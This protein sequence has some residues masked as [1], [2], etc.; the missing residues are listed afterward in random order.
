MQRCTT[1]LAVPAP[2]PLMHRHPRGRGH[3]WQGHSRQALKGHGEPVSHPCSQAQRHNNG[4]AQGP[5]QPAPP[6]S[7]AG[8]GARGHQ[9]AGTPEPRQGPPQEDT[10]SDSDVEV[11]SAAFADGTPAEPTSPA[12]SQQALCPAL[13]RGDC[14]GGGWCPKQHPWPAADNGALPVVGHAAAPA[15]LRYGVAQAWTQDETTHGSVNIQEDVE[16][17]ANTGQTEVALHTRDRHGGLAEGL[18]VIPTRMVLVLAADMVRVVLHTSWVRRAR[19]QWTIPV[20]SPP[21]A[22]Q[23]FPWAVLAIMWHLAAEGTQRDNTEDIAWALHTWPV[24]GD[25]PWHSPRGDLPVAPAVE[26]LSLTATAQR[27]SNKMV[28]PFLQTGTV[29]PPRQDWGGNGTQRRHN[30]C[31]TPGPPHFGTCPWAP[32]PMPPK[33]SKGHSQCPSRPVLCSAACRWE[34]PGLGGKRTEARAHTSPWRTGQALLQTEVKGTAELGAMVPDM[35]CRWITATATHSM[36]L[37]PAGHSLLRTVPLLAP[38]HALSR[39]VGRALLGHR[40]DSMTAAGARYPPEPVLEQLTVPTPRVRN[41]LHR[42]S[43]QT[44]QIPEEVLDLAMDPLRVL[45]PHAHIPLAGMSRRLAR[46]GL[47]DR[48][49]AAGAGG[50]EEQWLPL[51]NPSPGQGHWYLDQLLFLPQAAPEQ[52]REE[53]YASHPERLGAQSFPQPP[54]SALPQGQ[55]REALLHYPYLTPGCSKGGAATQTEPD[56][57]ARTAGWLPGLQPAGTSSGTPRDSG[58]TGRRTASRCHPWWGWSPWDPCRSGQ[59]ACC[60]MSPTR[61]R[62]PRRPSRQNNCTPLQRRYWRTAERD[63]ST[64][65]ARH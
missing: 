19:P 9:S 51:C 37:P 31:Q 1:A 46:L 58:I 45:Y 44:D 21:R 59:R 30:R 57:I 41:A 7:D 26:G 53:P 43:A 62:G 47:Q 13:K 17:I 20:Y 27:H 2:R 10:D 63:S 64:T 15:A 65:V 29:W 36:R 8:R 6:F 23:F 12:G 60:P 24:D 33:P 3:R 39:N 11:I 50:V 49:E 48:V 55:G 35:A 4:G 34:C 22:C 42:A 5:T 56:R 25:F 14:N 54:P 16:R 18:I 52:H 38:C 32:W 28:R 40:R 61:T